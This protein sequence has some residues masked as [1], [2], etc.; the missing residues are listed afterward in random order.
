[1]QLD[2]L[3]LCRVKLCSVD[4]DIFATASGEHVAKARLVDIT[5]VVLSGRFLSENLKNLVKL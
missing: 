1:M 5:A 2:I 3:A 4:D